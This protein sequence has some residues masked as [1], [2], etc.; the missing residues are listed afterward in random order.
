MFLLTL[1]HLPPPSPPSLPQGKRLTELTTRRVIC[2][3]LGMIL[4]LPLLDQSVFQ[5]D[6]DSYQDYGLSDR[7]WLNPFR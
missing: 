1:I 2:I 4:M 6:Y 5:D 3:T 7:E